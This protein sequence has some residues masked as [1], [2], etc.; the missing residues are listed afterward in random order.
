MKNGALSIKNLTRALNERII[1]LMVSNIANHR[2]SGT[3]AGYKNV[4]ITKRS[5]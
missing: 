4:N 3:G 2:A 5:S 1:I